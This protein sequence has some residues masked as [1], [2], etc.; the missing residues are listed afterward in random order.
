MASILRSAGMK[1]II[2]DSG[3][4]MVADFSQLD[5]PS[6]IADGDNDPLDFRFVRWMCRE[7]ILEACNDTK[8]CFYTGSNKQDNDNFIRVCFFKS[9]KVLDAAES[10]LKS[11]QMA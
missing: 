10:I 9:D 5:G 1:P 8:F 4:F 6:K 2:P 3:Y 7:K 11:F